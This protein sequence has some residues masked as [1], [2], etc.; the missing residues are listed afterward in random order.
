M[1]A[2]LSALKQAIGPD[3]AQARVRELLTLSQRSRLNIEIVPANPAPAEANAAPWTAIV[4]SIN[5]DHFVI[6]QP[7]H[8]ALVRPLTTGERLHITVRGP[9]GRYRGE[10]TVRGR[11]TLA[12]GAGGKLYGYALVFPPQLVLDERRNR[13]RL[14]L[15]IDLA[16][17]ATVEPL[18]G[19]TTPAPFKRFRAN[20][21]DVSLRGMRLRTLK[22]PPGFQKG[23][24]ARV[25]VELPDPVQTLS[26]VA[27][28][29]HAALTRKHDAF[30]IGLEFA[31]EI[32][33]LAEFIR[34]TEIRRRQR[35]R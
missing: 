5:D 27:I 21:L 23:L 3:P 10:L 8:G 18:P 24:Q 17:D 14:A 20:V 19:Q 22:A 29:R 34:R 9:E 30:L 31:E 15:G 16:L 2:F 1:G 35:Q 7:S 6:S 33:M 4:E 28:V 11:T 32:E 12:A 13:H 26:H 25:I